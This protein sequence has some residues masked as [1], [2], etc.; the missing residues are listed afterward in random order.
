MGSCRALMC[1]NTLLRHISTWLDLAS[2]RETPATAQLLRC[3]A[4]AR[5]GMPHGGG[6][7]EPEKGVWV[8]LGEG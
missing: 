3:E 7:G 8:S 1:Q 6:E 5:S 4:R 2:F